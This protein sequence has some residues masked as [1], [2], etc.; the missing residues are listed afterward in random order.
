MT[1]IVTNSHHTSIPIGIYLY[2]L[3]IQVYNRIWFY[4]STAK[5]HN[6]DKNFFLYIKS[7]FFEI[8]NL[9]FSL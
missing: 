2:T 8:D 5:I 7:A 9:L 1:I 3:V 6:M 4:I